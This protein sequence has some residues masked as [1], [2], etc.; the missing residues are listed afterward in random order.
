MVNIT[1]P[2]IGHCTINGTDVKRYGS[3]EVRMN[4]TFIQPPIEFF[5]PPY[6]LSFCCNFSYSVLYFAHL[7]FSVRQ[8]LQSTFIRWFIFMFFTVIVIIFAL[9]FILNFRLKLFLSIAWQKPNFWKKRKNENGITVC[10]SG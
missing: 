5:D 8:F 4:T 3:A 6:R 1:C 7:F 2:V 10:V 9:N